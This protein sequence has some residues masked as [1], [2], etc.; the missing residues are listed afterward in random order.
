MICL[1]LPQFWL[2]RG[3]SL[4]TGDQPILCLKACKSRLVFFFVRKNS[5]LRLTISFGTFNTDRNWKI[6]KEYSVLFIVKVREERWA[7]TVPAQVWSKDVNAFILLQQGMESTSIWSHDAVAFITWP[8]SQLSAKQH[9]QIINWNAPWGF[10]KKNPNYN[11]NLIWAAVK[12][13]ILFPIIISI[14][15]HC[16]RLF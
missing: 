2:S 4:L 14:Y 6:Q 9:L 12:C 10:F 7:W 8:E 5:S 15:T 13:I 16:T 3:S 11:D 1:W